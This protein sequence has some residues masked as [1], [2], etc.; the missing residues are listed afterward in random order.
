M[1]PQALY[2]LFYVDPGPRGPAACC[3]RQDFWLPTA[4]LIY[5]R[6]SPLSIELSVIFCHLQKELS[7]EYLVKYDLCHLHKELSTEYL[8]KRDLCHL[9]TGF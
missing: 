9:H 3:C 6:N 2:L 4:V 7:T 8:V 1:S 5:I